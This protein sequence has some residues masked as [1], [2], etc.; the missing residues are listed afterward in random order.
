MKTQSDLTIGRFISPAAQ[1]RFLAA[2][3]EAFE[4]LWP[5]TRTEADV[6]TRFGTTHVHRSGADAGDPV[7]LLHGANSNAV[8]WYPFVEALGAEHPVTAVDTIG[9]PGRSVA[10]A[11]IHEPADSAAWL[12]EVLNG[13]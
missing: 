9:D 7:V 1:T 10:R 6:E 3:D 13:L 12:D 11:A 2:Y 4:V 5:S 8:Q